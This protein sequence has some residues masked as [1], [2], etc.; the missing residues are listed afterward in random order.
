[1][2]DPAPRQPRASDIVHD[3]IR[4]RF[5]PVPVPSRAK[6]PR[7]KGWQNLRIDSPELVAR[8][9][10][11]PTNIGVKLGAASDGLVDVDID[12]AEALEFGQ[13]RLPYTAAKFGRAS[14]PASHRLYRV[15][16]PAPSIK[17]N[18]PISG[19]TLIELRGDKQDG[20]PGFQTIFPGSIHPSGEPIEWV[21]N[22]EPALVE[23]NE[24]KD[25]VLAVATQ[26]LLARYCPDAKSGEQALTAL[27][28]ADP[29][30]KEQIWR[31]RGVAHGQ[32]A[33]PKETAS[34]RRRRVADA[35]ATVTTARS[36]TLSAT[37]IA[38]VWT[39]LTF[40]DSRPRENWLKGG[41]ALY[42]IVAW[43][44]ELRREMFNRWS[45]EC[46]AGEPK[47]FREHGDN[48]S[49]TAWAS[50]KR[51]YTGERATVATIFYLARQGGWDG[52]TLKPQPDD[53]LR[54]LSVPEA[55]EAQK[56]ERKGTEQDS[57]G[58]KQADVLIKLARAKAKFWH[59]ADGT[60]F[61]DIHIGKHR[62]TWPVRSRNFKLW[63][64]RQ[65]YDN[66]RSAPNS[67]AVQSALNVLEAISHFDGPELPVSVRIAHANGKIYID[68][69]TA[70]WSTIEIDGNGWR[71][72]DEPPVHFRRSKGMLPLP[73]PKHNGD[74]KALRSFLNVQ[75]DE[76]FAL[77]VAFLVAALGGRG[78]FIILVPK[79]EHGTAKSTLTRII[80]TLCDPNI[81][82]L[83][84]LPR[85]DRDL[86]VSATNGY[87]LA[88]DNVSKLPGWLSDSL[89]RLA[90]GGGFG[91][92][93]LYTDT[94]EVLF[95]AMRPIILNGI[96]DFVTRA[97]LADRAAELTLAV[98]PDDK[99]R[100]EES[101]WAEFD[102]AAP[103][104]LGALL[105]AIACGLKRLP[106]VKFARKPRMADFA[107]WVVACE[108]KLPW[109]AGTFMRA[110]EGTRAESIETMLE[111]EGVIVV[112]RAFLTQHID[113]K[114]T[115]GALLKALNATAEEEV[116]K[117]KD[118]PKTP[119][120]MS[121]ALRRAA[122]GLRKLGYTVEFPG[123]D[124]SKKR[125]R[126]MHLSRPVEVRQQSSEPSNSVYHGA[127]AADGQPPQ[128][129]EQPSASK[130]L[131][132]KAADGA[133]GADGRVQ[134]FK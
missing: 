37:D 46:D 38:E 42:D 129:S 94:E 15:A 52:H 130:A 116:K 40:I 115:S 103:L 96:E 90:T 59:S 99:R 107:R 31:W 70:D 120:G 77:V 28:L 97:D 64:G 5:A 101:F 119:R 57:E 50:F 27:E 10:V 75:N 106:D 91:T 18:D 133:D 122:P 126:L 12:C 85:D 14:K 113:W 83:R 112:L 82:P 114:G 98:I 102:L 93:Q 131:K 34:R 29:R 47:K 60:A 76:D 51:P 61:V 1:M 32:S 4:R 45:I 67:D 86:F 16:G 117:A 74:I 9:F 11:D 62:E 108:H 118:W 95:D 8:Y 33:Q 72:V 49:D 22:G 3:F 80:R 24:L 92:R 88:F 7:L 128:P 56:C 30:I 111:S 105:D 100:D 19:E 54:F 26:V 41:G 36:V 121:G 104:I 55:E 65:Y 58:A 89:C 68:L 2:N 21:E 23:Y 127:F 73:L 13:R 84:S 109:T 20:T 81:A 78:P 110:Y 134:V 53:F 43:P 44:E 6:G 25:R 125:N 63:L 123:R 39:A 124:I 17:L 66:R 87:V 35:L 132:N 71:I 48:S 79:G 69:G